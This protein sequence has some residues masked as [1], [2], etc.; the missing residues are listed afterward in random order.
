VPRA[1]SPREKITWRP[2]RVPG[3]SHPGR[4]GRRLL[5]GLG[6]EINWN[7]DARANASHFSNVP[8]LSRELARAKERYSAAAFEAY[9]S[10]ALTLQPEFG[11][12]LA[13]TSWTNKAEDAYRSQWPKDRHPD[14][15][16]SWDEIFRR[17]RDPDRLPIVI[18]GP[19]DRLCGL[20]LALTAGRVINL[21]FLEGDP[22]SDCPLKG[23]RIAI[24]LEATAVYGQA[25][26]KGEITIDPVNAD[27]ENLYID[28][29]GFTKESVRG[30][31]PCFR[32]TI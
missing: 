19:S 31:K 6:F 16:W 15:G 21:R 5:S 10:A 4:G 1:K 11:L 26:G 2:S 3:S 23:R 17:H 13:I 25:L 28:T 9:R 20:G 32:R 30:K 7:P 8:V 22:R 12:H 18:W 24:A 29:Y 14:A 27:L